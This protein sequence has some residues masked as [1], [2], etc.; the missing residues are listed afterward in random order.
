MAGKAFLGFYFSSVWLWQEFCYLIGLRQIVYSQS[1]YSFASTLQ[2]FQLAFHTMDMTDKFE[3]LVKVPSGEP[4]YTLVILHIHFKIV[5]KPF[6]K[7]Q[8]FNF[9]YSS[10]PDVVHWS[11]LTCFTKS[12]EHVNVHEV[13][14]VFGQRVS[15]QP[16]ELVGALYALGL[17]VCPVQL[18]LMHSQAKGVRELAADQNLCGKEEKV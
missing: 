9:Y 1:A 17:P 6:I 2:S 7:D 8:I 4:G 5:T 11:T 3:G 14:Q 16:G 18:V 13:L 15:A 10:T 12:V